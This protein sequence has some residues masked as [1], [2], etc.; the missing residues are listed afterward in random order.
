MFHRISIIGFVGQAPSMR[1][2]EDGTP[3]A[4]LWNKSPELVARIGLRD[5]LGTYGNRVA[6]EGLDGSSGL[7]PSGI[8]REFCRQ[9]TVEP[10]E[11]WVGGASGRLPGIE[12]FG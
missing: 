11:L 10:N 8:D 9:V 12:A 7:Q 3:V 1:Y 2:T 5:G 4:K 6:R